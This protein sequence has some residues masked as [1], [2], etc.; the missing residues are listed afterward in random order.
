MHKLDDKIRAQIAAR[1]RDNVV[2][3]VSMIALSVAIYLL[4]AAV[5]SYITGDSRCMWVRCTIELGR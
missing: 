4:I 5:P 1:S 2:M 3:A